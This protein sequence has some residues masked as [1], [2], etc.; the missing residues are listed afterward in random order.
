MATDSQ[1]EKYMALS[2]SYIQQAEEELRRDDLLQAGEKAWGAVS[3]A[4]KAV[5]EDRGWFHGHHNLTH[6]ALFWLA[7]ES[8]I[9]K[10]KEAFAVV[11]Q[12][13]RNFYENVLT[14]DEVAEGLE[15]ARFILH[16]VEAL[17]ATSPGTHKFVPT[18]NRQRQRWENLT[19]R[20]WGEP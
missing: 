2:H 4:I 18:S 3:T 14:E 7:D 20:K 17:R 16:E 11:D 9:A 10:L 12:L 19:G 13:H 6:E 1:S 15:R 8:G 5:A